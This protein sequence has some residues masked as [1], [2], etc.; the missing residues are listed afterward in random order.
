MNGATTTFNC[1]IVIKKLLY[2]S[3]SAESVSSNK[4]GAEQFVIPNECESCLNEDSKRLKILKN[5]F[6]MFKLRLFSRCQ[7][8]IMKY[9]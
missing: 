2:D 6:R 7:K 5:L 3:L 8:N 1:H 9:K 4:S